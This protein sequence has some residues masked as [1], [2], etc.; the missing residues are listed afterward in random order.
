MYQGSA[1]IDHVFKGGFK[2]LC[3]GA[4]GQ[5]PPGGNHFFFCFVPFEVMK[6]TRQSSTA[7][8]KQDG[9]LAC[10]FGACEKLP[11]CTFENLTT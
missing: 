9:V 7:D 10:T 3:L 8:P 1:F 6:F 11:T 2:A 4:G 5:L